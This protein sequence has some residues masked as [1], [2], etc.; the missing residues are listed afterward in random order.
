MQVNM[1]EN[2][3]PGSSSIVDAWR[4]GGAMVEGAVRAGR[5]VVEVVGLHDDDQVN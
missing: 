3:P 2:G 4:V 5:G 1:S